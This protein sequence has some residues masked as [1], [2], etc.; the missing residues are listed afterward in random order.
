MSDINI[1]VVEDESII[2]MDLKVRL[3]KLGYG[4]AGLVSSGEE[5]VAKALDL[6]PNLIL[7]DIMLRGGIDGVEAA[8]QIQAQM[9]IPVIFVTA[10]SDKHT[11]QRA[12]LTDP[13][14]YLTKP[15]ED[16]NLYT[17]IEIALYKHSA[18]K[19]LKEKEQWLAATLRSIGDGV[20]TTDTYGRVTFMNP[21]AE[22]LTGWSSEEALGDQIDQVFR[23]NDAEGNTAAGGHLT[24]EGSESGLSAP[25]LLV[26]RAGD[27]IPVEKTE[28]AIVGERGQVAGKVVTFRNVADRQRAE[29]ELRES[30]VRYRQLALENA[31]LLEQ[32][33]Q[34]TETKSRLLQEINHRV[35]NNLSVILGLIYAEQCQRPANENIDYQA[36][37]AGLA[38]RIRSLSTVHNMLS[39][40]EWTPLRLD[41]LSQ[42]VIFLVLQT[43]PAGKIVQVEVTPSL[44]RVAPKQA[45]SLALV[46]NEMMTNVAKHA[47]QVNHVIRVKVSIHLVNDEVVYEF[48][49]SGPGY[50]QQ[51]LALNQGNSGLYLINNIVRYDLSGQV[52]FHNEHGA[53]TTIRFVA[54]SAEDEIADTTGLTE[55]SAANPAGRL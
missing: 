16:A 12:K 17:A 34:D 42:E 52:D 37:M 41:E 54:R 51:V 47:A 48:R 28:T 18:E 19:S 3:L 8:R 24:L 40:S 26:S 15:F 30:E 6:Q 35:K 1:L 31:V 50:P 46:I 25:R 33:R 4:V 39:R 43:L 21:V 38:T 32:A 23:I 49:D 55:L 36:L 27:H 10:Y 44:V 20:I 7:M 14:G 5:A 45:S 9:S 22:A 13:F 29:R 11:L 53:V 2:A